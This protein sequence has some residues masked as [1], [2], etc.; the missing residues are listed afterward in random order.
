MLE[1]LSIRNFKA[2]SKLDLRL[3][4]LVVLT[5]LN[6][7]GKSTVLQSLAALKQ[8]VAS[9][10]SAGLRLRGALVQLGTCSDIYTEGAESER[11]EIS[12]AEKSEVFSWVMGD[13]NPTSAFLQFS[14]KPD[15]MP[16]FL[17]RG[18]FQLLPAD[19]IVPK[20]L[21]SRASDSDADVGFLGP[22][23]EFVVEFLLSEIARKLVVSQFRS[24]PKKGLDLSD[25][26]LEKAAPTN[27]LIDQVS[28]WLQQLSPGVRVSAD[29]LLSTDD[30][31]LRF[32][33]VGRSGVSESS[34]LIRPANVGF[35]LTYCLPIIVACLAATRGSLL[36]LEN[37]EAHLH[38]Q[39]Q[40]A[41]GKLIAKAASDG[42][43]VLVETHSDHL[44]N[45]IRVA[46]KE[47]VLPGNEVSINFFH[48]D[49]ATG[50]VSVKEPELSDEGRLSYWPRGFFDQFERDLAQL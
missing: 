31:L 40:A 50:F 12:I 27:S 42:V 7:S 9:S 47:R 15:R 21:F 44:L 32:G 1:N 43:Q 14:E 22:R 29:E 28:G 36:L 41:L 24:F 19:R 30:V 35:G 16:N 38:P 10:D 49:I 6:G 13:F 18:A 4:P 25:S 34:K 48:R 5:G 37:P 17:R 2:A 11:I 26:L 46:V 3:S 23:G 33:Y 45:G 39:G 8:S 20:N